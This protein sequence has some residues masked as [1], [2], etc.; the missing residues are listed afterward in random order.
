MNVGR[1]RVCSGINIGDSDDGGGR[2]S[3]A[4]K[5]RS[6]I[7]MEISV[8]VAETISMAVVLE[9]AWAV[10]FTKAMLLVAAMV[11]AVADLVLAV[12]VPV[13]MGRSANNYE[14]HSGS[15]NIFNELCS[16]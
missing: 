6:D 11:V 4:D 12:A 1:K 10:L 8:V 16:S 7:V 2:D 5:N 13:T 9:V 14:T 15:Y 3:D